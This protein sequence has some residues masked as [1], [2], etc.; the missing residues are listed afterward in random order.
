MALKSVVDKSCFE[1]V[2]SDGDPGVRN[3]LVILENI[4]M[5][6]C[7]QQGIS[8]RTFLS[9]PPFHQTKKFCSFLD[10]GGC[11]VNEVFPWK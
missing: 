5:H 4:L 1:G 8:Y 3:L 2:L 6:R 9:M 11:W 10:E 7:K